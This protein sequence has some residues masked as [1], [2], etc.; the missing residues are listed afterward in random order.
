TEVIRLDGSTLNQRNYRRSKRHEQ[1]SL[2]VAVSLQRLAKIFITGQ[3]ETDVINPV[4]CDGVTYGSVA[5]SES[6]IE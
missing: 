2:G 5:H 3:A 4:A 6:L 1:L